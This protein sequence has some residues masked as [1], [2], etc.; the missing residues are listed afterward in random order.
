MPSL[1]DTIT[2]DHILAALA[3]FDGGS[4]HR[5]ADSTGY[6]LLYEG[7]RYPP[8]AIVGIAARAVT[9]VE[10]GPEDFSG[11]R[12]RSAS[13]FSNGRDSRS[14]R[15]RFRGSGSFRGTRLASTSRTTLAVTGSST[16]A[17]PGIAT[18]S[19]SVTAAA[20]GGREPRLG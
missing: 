20:S 2:R 12:A 16:G 4:A 15:R 1:P 13:G 7:R 10:H 18:P 11:A 8:K 17:S 3:A 14:S 5:F 19:D 6:D 9:G